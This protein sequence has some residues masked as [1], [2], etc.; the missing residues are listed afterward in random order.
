MPL[1]STVL[2][3]CVIVT[4][5]LPYSR[6]IAQSEHGSAASYASTQGLNRVRL[7][8]ESTA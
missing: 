4:L 8:S 6:A 2:P 5:P 3:A 7:T 1:S